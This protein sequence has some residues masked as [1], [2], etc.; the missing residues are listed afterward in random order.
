MRN[1]K[2][3]HLSFSERSGCCD[4]GF[5]LIEVLVALFIFSVGL[6]GLAGMMGQSLR[7]N[8]DA[9]VRTQASILAYDMM[10]RMRAD[11]GNVLLY[12][13]AD[14]DP[15]DLTACDPVNVSPLNERVCWHD[16][17]KA[18]LPGGSAVVD[19]NPD[20]S[21]QFDIDISWIN[22]SA[23]N[24]DPATWRTFTQSWTVVIN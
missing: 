23:E 1:D 17:V 6:L 5:T 13:G 24:D 9:Y 12:Q 14:P 3:S 19:E 8:H 10:D 2:F 16:A 11:A 7:S 4:A 20:D 22:R 15:D 21:G 18:S